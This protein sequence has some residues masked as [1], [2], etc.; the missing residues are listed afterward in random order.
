M[1]DNASC[2][3]EMINCINLYFNEDD[4]AILYLAKNALT[5]HVHFNNILLAESANAESFQVNNGVLNDYVNNCI[6]FNISTGS[7]AI[8]ALGRKNDCM[9]DEDPFLT[10]VESGWIAETVSVIMTQSNFT[11]LFESPVVNSG[12]D[13][14]EWLAYG[15]EIDIIGNDR[16]FQFEGVD[17]GPYEL[18]IHIIDICGADIKSVDQVKVEIDRINRRLVSLV[19][20]IVYTGL[21]Q[22][23][24]YDQK[25][26]EEFVREEKIAIVLKSSDPTYALK[27]DKVNELLAEF[28]AKY[29]SPTKTI[30]VAKL[31]AETSRRLG[32]I[33]EDDTYVLH[34]NEQESKLYL[35]LN[36]APRYG[37][38]G[39]S[40]PIKNVRFGGNPTFS[41]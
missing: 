25:A 31:G 33:M 11:P 36:E 30:V 35:Y 40:N 14:P 13:G 28:E 23:F 15:I 4:S 20:D 9:E 10:E 27:S 24:Q 41:G 39:T 12:N 7:F 29:D 2:R 34:F 17:I 3:I 21:W 22:R 37:M 26:M 32:Q 8:N 19:N 16:T 1:I 5:G 38:C 6:T 18:E